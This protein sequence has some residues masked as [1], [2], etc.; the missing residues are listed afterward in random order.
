VELCPRAIVLDRG[1]IVA[2]GPTVELLNNEELM[3]AH[4][5]ECPHIL[6]H[7]HPH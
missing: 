4:G 6:R 3:L 1:Q 7:V 2:D 5:L